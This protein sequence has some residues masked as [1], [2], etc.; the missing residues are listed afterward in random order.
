MITLLEQTIPVERIWIETSEKQHE[1][2]PGFSDM[3]DKELLDLLEKS[4]KVVEQTADVDFETAVTM[5][6]IDPAFDSPRLRPLIGLIK[7]GGQ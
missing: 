7:E 3:S 5:I 6:E 2:A 4:I 1:V